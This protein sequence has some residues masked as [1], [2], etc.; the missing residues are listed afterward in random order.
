MKTALETNLDTHLEK[1]NLG[2]CL[3]KMLM[4]FE[5]VLS[6]FWKEETYP[7]I[8][9]PFSMLREYAVPV[10]ML[11]SFYLT[12]NIV[13]AKN[14]EKYNKRFWRLIYPQLIWA[15]VYWIIYQI[16]EIILKRSFVNGIEDLLWQILTGHS[17]RLNPAMWYQTV[18]IL[19]TLVFTVLFYFLPQKIAVTGLY[20]FLFL[21]LFSQYTGLNYRLFST[22]RY[23]LMYP[24]GRS[25]EMIPYAVIGFLLG[26]YGIPEKLKNYKR[27]ITFACCVIGGIILKFGLPSAK[28]FGYS[29]LMPLMIA[30]ILF[31]ITIYIPL[32]KLPVKFQI[33][34]LK[35]SRYTLGIYCMHNLVGRIL[36]GIFGTNGKSFLTCCAIYIICYAFSYIICKFPLKWCRQ[37][38]E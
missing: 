17:Q 2:I 31:T 19:L 4:C 5:V 30:I 33:M 14:R 20:L 18:L 3:L 36:S 7:I 35:I 27:V 34:I 13:L 6:H 29:G 32:E 22:L 16:M 26:Y 12:Q 8:L 38:V 21:S 24:L 10:F 25:C 11:M 15:F 9:T 28:G 23:E 37:L 1:K